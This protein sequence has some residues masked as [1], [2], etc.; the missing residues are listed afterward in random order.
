MGT[1]EKLTNRDRYFR[2]LQQELRLLVDEKTGLLSEEYSELVSCPLCDSRRSRVLFVKEGYTF[3]RCR[4][5]AL[6]FTNPQVKEDL[7]F[8]AYRAGSANDLWVDVL[9]S[10]TQLKTDEKKYNE[11]LDSLES[12]NPLKGRLLDIGCSIGFFLHLASKR[13]WEV[14]GLE[15]GERASQ[16]AREK[17]GINVRNQTLQGACF[18]D[19]LFDAVAVLG[20][21]EHLKRPR[22]FLREVNRVTKPSGVLVAITPNVDSL[23]TKILH[24]KAA[25]FDGRNHLVYFSPATLTRLLEEGGVPGG[26]HAHPGLLAGR[27]SQLSGFQ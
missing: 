4:D 25:T 20:I 17:F 24:E 1:F 23:A 8:E 27:H 16:Y 13:R 12:L 10:E 5:C 2:Q 7:L 19:A 6:V 21:L 14:T 11:I 9:T 3:V 15:L 22:E 26:L 18:A